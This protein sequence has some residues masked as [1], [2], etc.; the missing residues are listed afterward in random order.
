MP[1]FLELGDFKRRMLRIDVSDFDDDLNSM[2]D[3]AEHRI[4]DPYNGILRRPVLR[5]SFEEQFEAFVAVD[6]E[7]PDTA[8][9][10]SVTYR[11]RDG[12][13]QTL[14]GIFTLKSGNLCLNFGESWPVHA[15]EISVSYLAGWPVEA[16][17]EPIKNACY[18]AAQMIWDGENYNDRIEAMLAGYRRTKL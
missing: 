16:V 6:L 18:V 2:L 3:A 10:V 15:G 8:E 17:P 14:P 1:E 9:I 4:G 7:F 13:L 11:D 5:Q 12:S